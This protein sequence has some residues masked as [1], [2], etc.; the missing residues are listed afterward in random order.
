MLVFLNQTCYN[1][2]W[3][4]RNRLNTIISC[5]RN[6]IRSIL[7]H[8]NSSSALSQAE[9]EDIERVIRILI[10]FPFAVKNHLRG[11]WGVFRRDSS[12]SSPS[13]SAYGYGGTLADSG[14]GDMALYNAEYADLLPAGF[15]GREFDGL[16]LPY[17]LTFFVDSFVKR[18]LQRGWFE[19]PVASMLQGLLNK[20]LDAFGDMET[21]MLT[22]PPVAHL[23]VPLPLFPIYF[24]LFLIYHRKI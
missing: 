11:E 3:D 16:G 7:T 19:P 1:R 15:E 14:I 24:L 10:A 12:F 22:P 5:T 4:G 8:S 9:K 20:A 17:Q 6:L 2:F 21:I 13:S 23:F 18:G